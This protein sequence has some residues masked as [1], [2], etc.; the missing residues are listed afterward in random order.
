MT[1]SIYAHIDSNNNVFYIGMGKGNRPY[2]LTS[3]SDEHKKHVKKHGIKSVKIILG[4]LTDKKT[5]RGLETAITELY[6]SAGEPLVNKQIGCGGKYNNNFKGLTIGTKDNHVVIMSGNDDIK[7]RGFTPSQVNE[8]I[9]GIDKHHK[10][11]T[12]IRIKD[13]RSLKKY[14][15]MVLDQK[16]TNVLNDFMNR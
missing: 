10:G 5:A 16:S 12:F 7:D 11:Y 4:N 6:K 9:N 2:N 1:Y 14:Q 8:V 3:R 13:K 15:R